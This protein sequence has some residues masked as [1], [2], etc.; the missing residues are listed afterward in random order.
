MVSNRVR[1]NTQWPIQFKIKISMAPL[2]TKKHKPK[3]AGNCTVKA[4]TALKVSLMPDVKI[5]QKMSPKIKAFRSIS[6]FHCTSNLIFSGWRCIL[7]G[8]LSLLSRIC[9]SLTSDGARWRSARRSYARPA[10]HATSRARASSRGWIG[11][12]EAIVVV[13]MY[14]K[15]E[16]YSMY[17]NT[18]KILN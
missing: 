13:D 18:T 7:S 17:N 10:T 11:A 3:Q 5:N 1:L 16:R 8:G 12:I 14:F 9:G 2:K 6:A 4:R 15:M